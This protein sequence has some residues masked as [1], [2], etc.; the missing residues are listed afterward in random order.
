MRR[1]ARHIHKSPDGWYSYRRRVPANL[2]PMFEGRSEIKHAYK[3]KNELKA[4]K[5][6]ASFHDSVEREFQNAKAML[7]NIAPSKQEKKH[8]TPSKLFLDVYNKLKS[9]GYLPH[10]M[11]SVDVTM[12]EVERLAWAVDEVKYAEAV[13]LYNADAISFQQYQDAIT[14]LKH[15]PFKR[16]AKHRDLIRFLEEQEDIFGDETPEE[17]KIELKILKGDYKSPDPNVED[18]FNHYIDMKGSE[19]REGRRNQKQQVKLENSIKRILALLETALREGSKTLIDDLDMTAIKTAFE[20]RFPRVDTRRRNYADAAAAVNLWNKF[21]PS[22]RIDNPFAELKDLLGR[23][24]K[25]R[26]ERRVWHPEE[27]QKFLNEIQHEPELSRK[28]MCML[29]A[30]AGKPQGETAGLIRDDLRLNYEVPHI[31]F[32]SNSYRVLGKKRQENMLPLVGDMLKLMRDYE[33]TFEGGP[34]DLL[35]PDLYRMDSGSR[36]KAVNKYSTEIHPVK[37]TLFQPYGLRHTFKPRYEAA[38]V[39]PIQGMYLFGHQNNLTSRT[40]EQYA[41]GANKLEDF[42]VLRDDMLKIIAVDAWEYN[43]RISDFE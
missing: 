36:S 11:P 37:D 4:L 19:T 29:M 7:K 32:Q 5:L 6:H 35:F 39:A 3:T 25:N 18:L 38:G 17:S 9:E 24:D 15:E 23:D 26:R 31:L 33:A 8:K 28:I 20:N 34:K 13:I 43:Y 40:H 21:K 10:Q 14:S 2:Q 27:Y 1:L 30:Y 16:F 12:T 22:K 41:K 42:I